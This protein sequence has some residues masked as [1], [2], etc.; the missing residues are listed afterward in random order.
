MNA[1]RAE[2]VLRRV[3]SVPEGHVTTYGDLS[4]GAPRF[5][6]TVLSECHDPELPW[7]R[8]VRA[9]GSLAKGARQRRLLAAEGVP[10]RG[11]RVD[12][13]EAWVPV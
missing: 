4:P 2:E 8:I 9:D 5:A 7:H 1:E 10:L 6:G 13:R 3:R 11:D 12:M